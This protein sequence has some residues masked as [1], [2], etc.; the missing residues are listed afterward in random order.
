MYPINR[1]IMM[2]P[3]LFA[4]A[5]TACADRSQDIETCMTYPKNVNEAI[6]ACTRLIDD[7]PAMDVARH[8]WFAAR[9][10]HRRKAGDQKGAMADFDEAIRLMPK[11]PQ[12]YAMRAEF[13]AELGHAAKADADLKRAAQLRAKNP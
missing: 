3:V 4:M 12:L 11:D 13:H 9:G 5:T 1:A 7:P 10:N 2:F 6:A 8:G